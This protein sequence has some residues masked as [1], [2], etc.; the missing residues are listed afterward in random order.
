MGRLGRSCRAGIACSLQGPRESM[1]SSAWRPRPRARPTS[2]RAMPRSFDL[3]TPPQAST[4]NAAS[5]THGRRSLHRQTRTRWCTQLRPREAP[6]RRSTSPSITSWLRPS[7]R[8][9]EHGP[10][11]GSPDCPNRTGA[12]LFGEPQGELEDRHLRRLSLPP[13]QSSSSETSEPSFR[14]LLCCL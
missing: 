3:K 2:C 1:E 6:S 5:G 4:P 13:D 12:C 10:R 7:H 14:F 11:H 9:G 8:T